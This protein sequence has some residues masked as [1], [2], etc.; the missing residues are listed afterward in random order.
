MHH[1]KLLKNVN[2]VQGMVEMIIFGCEMLNI[3]KITTINL[4]LCNFI[5]KIAGVLRIS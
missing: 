5:L 1:V 3:K 4:A 2:I